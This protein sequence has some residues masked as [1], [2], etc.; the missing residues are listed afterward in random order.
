MFDIALYF[1]YHN[2]YGTDG[3]IIFARKPER[4]CHVRGVDRIR[5]GLSLRNT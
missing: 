3:M 4:G 5:F 1:K 2:D